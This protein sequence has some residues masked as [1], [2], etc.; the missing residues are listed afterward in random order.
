M[1]CDFSGTFWTEAADGNRV[2]CTIPDRRYDCE[3]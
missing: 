1:C 3:Y 2:L